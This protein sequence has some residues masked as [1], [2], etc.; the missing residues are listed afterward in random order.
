MTAPIP[1]F[2]R[3]LR[4]PRAPGPVSGDDPHL[5]LHHSGSLFP[6]FKGFGSPRTTR[7][8]IFSM[9]LLPARKG[10]YEGVGRAVR[11]RKTFPVLPRE[12]K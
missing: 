6:R 8:L 10:R 1:L 3:N 2:F 11:P 7:P 9:P 5:P 12:K 4:I